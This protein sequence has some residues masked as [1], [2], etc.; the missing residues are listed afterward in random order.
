MAGP[1]ISVPAVWFTADQRDSTPTTSHRPC[2]NFGSRTC[3]RRSPRR[4]C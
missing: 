2:G 3:S 1:R 4:R